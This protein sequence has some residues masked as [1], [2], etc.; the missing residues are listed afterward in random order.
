MDEIKIG[1][2]FGNCMTRGGLEFEVHAQDKTDVIVSER[3]MLL[4][5][6]LVL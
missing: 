4:W 6:L 3:E 5:T 1:D 2:I